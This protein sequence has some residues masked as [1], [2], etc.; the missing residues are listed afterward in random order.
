MDIF[1]QFKILKY[2]II[3]IT[4]ALYRILFRKFKQL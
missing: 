3:K 2:N 1:E 4:E